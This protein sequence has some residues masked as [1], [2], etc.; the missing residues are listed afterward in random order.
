MVRTRYTVCTLNVTALQ[1][2]RDFSDGGSLSTNTL[3]QQLELSGV[4]SLA[5]PLLEQLGRELGSPS[6][7]LS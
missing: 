5:R 1:A 2:M 7:L 4:H 6:M 3:Y